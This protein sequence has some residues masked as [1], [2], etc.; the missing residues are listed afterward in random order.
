MSRVRRASRQRCA[1]V[2]PMFVPA[3]VPAFVSAFVSASVF[4]F[5]S[6]VPLC[7]LDAFL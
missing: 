5:V 6:S 2:V 1:A 3:F 4:A 7:V